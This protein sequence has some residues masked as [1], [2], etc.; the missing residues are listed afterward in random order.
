VALADTPAA[1]DRLDKGF[2]AQRFAVDLHDELE[3]RQLIEQVVERCGGLD[4]LV[5]CAAYVGTTQVPGWGVPFDEQSVAAWDSALRVN[6]TAAFVLT[7]AARPHLA[8]SGHGSVV[9]VSSI[10]GLIGPDWSLYQGTTMANP[11]AYGASKAGLRQLARYLSTA[12]APE[13]RVNVLTPGGVW[14]G[15]PDSFVA[16]Y[17]ARTPLGRMACEGDFKGAIAFL[18]SDLSAYVTGQEL[19]VDGGFTAW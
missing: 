8:R 19:V 3:T 18:A 13:I 16:R 9:F 6:L 17:E 12:F 5:H 2:A 7:Q 14:R 15:Q 10:Y 11:A 1:L 4:V